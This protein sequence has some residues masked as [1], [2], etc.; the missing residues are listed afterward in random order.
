MQQRWYRLTTVVVLAQAMVPPTG[1]MDTQ[2]PMPMNERYLKRFPQDTRVGDLIGLPVLDLSSST[3]GYVQQVVRTPAG[4]TKV[5]VKYSRWWGWFGRP[6]A[7]PLE[8]LGIEGQQLVSLDMPPSEY[9][10]APIWHG[11]AVT[12]LP[13]IS[14]PSAFAVLRFITRSNLVGCTTGKSPGLAP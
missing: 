12:P 3:L 9:A 1:M 7:V 2:H 6:V 13:G 8:A 14:S 4:E 10:V 5:I 11:T